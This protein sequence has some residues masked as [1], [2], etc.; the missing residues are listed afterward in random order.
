[1][2]PIWEDEY[3]EFEALIIGRIMT[4]LILIK[5]GWFLLKLETRKLFTSSEKKEFVTAGNH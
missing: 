4:G 1:M 2:E 5:I 3:Y